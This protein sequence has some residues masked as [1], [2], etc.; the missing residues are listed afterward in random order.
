MSG[1][2]SRFGAQDKGQGWGS[3]VGE[4]SWLGSREGVMVGGLGGGVR[5]RAVGEV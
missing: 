5:G 2:G 1:E 3:R 4:G